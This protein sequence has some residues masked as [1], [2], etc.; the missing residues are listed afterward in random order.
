M[1]LLQT[2]ADLVGHETAQVVVPLDQEGGVGSVPGPGGMEWKVIDTPAVGPAVNPSYHG[3]SFV[4]KKNNPGL[5]A[6]VFSKMLKGPCVDPGVGQT[7]HY[8][9]GRGT[10]PT[11]TS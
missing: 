9:R 7:K 6:A 1:H 2:I 4:S 10:R 8:N 5:A 11:R 3:P